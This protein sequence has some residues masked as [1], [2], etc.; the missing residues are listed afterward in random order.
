M[1]G[2]CPEQKI[3]K[4]KNKLRLTVSNNSLDQPLKGELAVGVPQGWVA[5]PATVSVDL[6]PN[7]WFAQDLVVDAVSPVKS[8]WVQAT[9]NAE[10]GDS[11]FDV[12]RIRKA[13]ELKATA[14]WAPCGP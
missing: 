11:Y 5:D 7:E 2:S 13:D 3:G 12:L 8:G 1:A 6:A 9:L 10:Q 14:D 4:G